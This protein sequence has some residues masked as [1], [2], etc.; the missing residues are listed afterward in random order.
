MPCEL[1]RLAANG[2]VKVTTYGQ[3]EDPFDVVIDHLEIVDGILKIDRKMIMR[4]Q[5]EFI[6]YALSSEPGK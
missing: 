3:K 1:V 5:I 6:E 4:E 2:V